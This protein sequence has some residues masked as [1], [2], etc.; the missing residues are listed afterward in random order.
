MLLPVA[1]IKSWHQV[2]LALSASTSPSWNRCSSSNSQSDSQ[3]LAGGLS[4]VPLITY[5]FYLFYSVE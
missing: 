2:I 4:L 3:G 1:P 5:S